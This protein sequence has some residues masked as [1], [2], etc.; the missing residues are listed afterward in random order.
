MRYFDTAKI[1]IKAGDGGNGCVA[2]R[3]EN[4]RMAPFLTRPCFFTSRCNARAHHAPT[5]DILACASCRHVP[6]GGPNGGN[7]GDGGN[8]LVVCSGTEK[9]LRHFRCEFRIYKVLLS[10]A[11][12]CKPLNNTT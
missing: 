11:M 2:F 9:S 8:V 4:Y 1:N 6:Y 5:H 3:R 12:R 10:P 7:G